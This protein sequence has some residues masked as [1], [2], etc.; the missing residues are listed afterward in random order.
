MSDL[1]VVSDDRTT[2][3]LY[4]GQ[5]REPLSEHSS[6]TD[7]M[8]AA[9]ARAQDRGGER[10]VVHDRYHRTHDADA[11][12]EQPTAGAHRARAY[13]PDAAADTVRAAKP[14]M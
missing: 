4:D 1:H 8:L 14:D 2:W 6:A 7:A 5:H 9:Q 13:Q 11:S 10:V 12:A 3:R